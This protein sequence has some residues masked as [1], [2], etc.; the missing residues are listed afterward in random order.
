MAREYAKI[1]VSIWSDPDFVRL[2]MASQHAYFTLVSQAK[3]NYCGV[4]DYLP[5]R[6]ATLCPDHDESSIDHAIKVLETD[7]FAIVDRSTSELL[8]RSFIRH[9][10]LLSMPNMTK[11][12]LKDFGS[13]IS[14]PLRDAVTRE[15]GKCYWMDRSLAGWKVLRKVSPDLFEKVTANPSLMGSGKGSAMG[16][17]NDDGMGS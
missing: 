10:G 6:L 12:L 1:K 9:D 14:E 16:S 8:V 7:R 5:A 11:A 2:A 4:M 17:G 15:M 13:V 3:L